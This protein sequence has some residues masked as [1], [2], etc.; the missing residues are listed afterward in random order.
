MRPPRVGIHADEEDGVVLQG[1][2][3]MRGEQAD[4]LACLGRLHHAGPVLLAVERLE[5]A[6]RQR[7][8]QRGCVLAAM[9][10][11]DEGIHI[12]SG[13]AERP[14]DDF[15]GAVRGGGSRWWILGLPCAQVCDG[16]GHF[17]GQACAVLVV[18]AADPLQDA[19]RVQPELTVPAWV[20]RQRQ[21]ADDIAG[22]LVLQD[23][24]QRMVAVSPVV[25]A[26]PD[27][28]V[29]KV[30]GQQRF[31]IG[32]HLPTEHGEI[33]CCPA[34]AGDV[35]GNVRCQ[36]GCLALGAVEGPDSDRQKYLLDRSFRDLR[37]DLGVEPAG[38]DLLQFDECG[39]AEP[40]TGELDTSTVVASA[41]SS[42]AIFDGLTDRERLI[43]ATI[44]L[45]VRDLGALIGTGKSQAA[46]I[47]R[48]VVE[49]VK[50]GWRTTTSLRRPSEGWS[51]FATIGLS[52][53]QAEL[54][55]RPNECVWLLRT[56]RTVRM[57]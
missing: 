49:R 21:H 9:L 31:P 36:N 55:R 25:V 27:A 52:R 3:P 44:E 4:S 34:A 8:K 17:V 45:N 32:D 20:G 28:P 2:A 11:S 37:D 38:D 7:V 15:E 33:G 42:A 6:L 30:L 40:A 48:R 29:A 41:L 50:A 16:A 13:R 12:T 10:R 46:E 51:G 43:V 19:E 22:H 54:V 18:E 35:V 39:A 5:Q 1:L 14:I 57:Q 56:E 26:Q 23:V 24:L 47:R 53:G